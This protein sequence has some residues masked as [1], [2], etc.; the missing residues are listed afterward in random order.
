[1]L[2]FQDASRTSLSG[3]HSHQVT[4]DGIEYQTKIDGAHSHE[5]KVWDTA[6]DGAHQHE[7]EL[8][9]IAVRTMTSGEYW[10]HLGK[11]VKPSPAQPAVD[12]PE[13]AS[14]PAVDE[15][16]VKTEGRI[17]ARI[18]FV[19]A[20]CSAIDG[21]R[22]QPFSGP[23][24]ETLI[25]E[26]LE[27]LGLDRSDCMLT[28]AV[29]LV[30][31]DSAGL[32]REPT[33]DEIGQ[34]QGW[35]TDELGTRDPDII[36]ALGK[37]AGLALGDRATHSLPHPA[38]VRKM[39]PPQSLK[40][41]LKAL[42]K[43]V[44]LLKQADEGGGDTREEA[45]QQAWDR[46]WET[47]LPTS[48]K[49]RY[50]L[51]YHWRGLK[52]EEKELSNEA[53]L[54]TD[55]SLHADLRL[56]GEDGLWGFAVLGDKEKIEAFRQGGSEK[57]QGAIKLRHPDSWLAPPILVPPG[58]P[59][60][61]SD[62]YAKFFAMDSGTYDLGVAHGESAEVVLDGDSLNGRYVFSHAPIDGRR[63]WLIHKPE[64][65]TPTAQREKTP[66]RLIRKLRGDKQRVLYWATP[67][68]RPRLIDIQTGKD[69]TSKR[70]EIAK[71]DEAKQIIYAVVLDPYK[72]GDA[73]DDWVPPNHVEETAHNWFQ[74]SRVIGRDHSGLARDGTGPVESHV[75]H[76]PTPDDYRAA[77][78]NRPHR[79]YRMP[80]GTTTVHSGA[81]ILGTKLGD[82][83]WAAY[84]RGEIDAYS[85]GGL[86]FRT[87][88]SEAQLPD[89]TFVDLAEVESSTPSR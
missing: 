75:V 79:A 69:Q 57:M 43:A 70:V 36:V 8:A 5:L 39:G 30:L 72:F 78:A 46:E 55:H 80:F 4:V 74:K 40:R 10:L 3:A 2:P 42:T 66:D 13:P 50:A 21:A 54:K 19:G 18:A 45:A 25:K 52:E 1:M 32:A 76:Y 28:T 87:P 89:V 81:W 77:I 17:D 11:P 51:Q 62:S 83:D 53:L 85:I 68:D 67:G 41:K 26:Y 82:E 84:K 12:A 16:V 37:T 31:K 61:A 22:G 15:P 38:I 27:P 49:G 64:D 47:M 9:E 88:I 23:I 33:A 58:G 34:W 60:A 14:R 20:S 7:L 24:G 71:A 56:E 59:G 35:L 63:I 44:R 48:G 86:G 65:Q 6:I 29:P 73:H